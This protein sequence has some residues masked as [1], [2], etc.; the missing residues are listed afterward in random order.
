MMSDVKR[1]EDEGACK[2]AV[3][4]GGQRQTGGSDVKYH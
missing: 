2:G 1:G 3:E 4:S